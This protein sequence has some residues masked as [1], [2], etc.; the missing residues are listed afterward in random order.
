[1]RLEWQTPLKRFVEEQ[2]ARKQEAEAKK[3]QEESKKDKPSSDTS[4]SFSLRIG[5]IDSLNPII[6]L[7]NAIEDSRWV[8]YLHCYSPLTFE[9]TPYSIVF[10]PSIPYNFHLIAHLKNNVG[11]KNQLT[12]QGN[13]RP[14]SLFYRD[15]FAW[16]PIA[17]NSVAFVFP[18]LPSLFMCQFIMCSSPILAGPLHPSSLVGYR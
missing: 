6:Q 15:A 8:F 9:E 14:V 7:S 13:E 1:M 18:V 2:R 4:N 5:S 16:K 10:F 3:R 17:S 11:T 12:I